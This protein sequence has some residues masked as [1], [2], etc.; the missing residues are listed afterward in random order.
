V[1][2]GGGIGAG[3]ELLLPDVRT[4]VARLVPVPPRI[5]QAALGERATRTG[6]VAVALEQARRTILARL[7]ART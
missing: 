3:A 7:S 5:E 2:L 6:A 4:A 1:L